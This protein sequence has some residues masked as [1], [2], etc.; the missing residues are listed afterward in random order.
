MRSL[1]IVFVVFMLPQV[2]SSMGLEAAF[3]IWKQ[4]P[5]GDIAYKGIS[6]DVKNDLN[7]GNN[8]EVF[9]RLKV[10]TPLYFPNIYFMATPMSFD[11]TGNKSSN[12]VFGKQTFIAAAPYTSHLKVD[13][14]D[15]ALYY[16]LPFVKTATLDLL[17]IDAG[18]DFRLVDFNASINQ[19]ATG[20]SESKR[21]TLPVPMG[22][23]GVQ[24]TP[25]KRISLE[26]EVRGVVF[27]RDQYIDLI[28][29]VK[30]KILGPAFVGAG[31]RYEYIK[32]DESS[33]NSGLRFGGPFA[34][35]GIEL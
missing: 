35:I 7:L 21:L 19:A 10:E 3:G 4:D 31:Y 22:Y 29:R 18:I 5:S 16:G 1:I 8:T 2:A 27:G 30:F 28:G 6:L 14:Y 17:N 24:V 11:G 23:L 20:L 34:E 32:V 15:F 26:G 12:F 33:V 25:L 9:G 13:H